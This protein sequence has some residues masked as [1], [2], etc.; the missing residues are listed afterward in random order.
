[1][2][3]HQSASGYLLDLGDGSIV[4][5]QTA[6]PY[7]ALKFGAKLRASRLGVIDVKEAAL[8][9]GEV[10]NRRVRWDEKANVVTERPRAAADHEAVRKHAKPLDA[11][12]KLYRNQIKNPLNP[13]E[14]VVLLD[15]SRFGSVGDALVAEDAAGGRLV[16]RDP[17]RAA[18]KTTL[19]LKN[20]A[21]AFGPEQI[22]LGVQGRKG[23]AGHARQATSTGQRPPYT[24][25]PRM[26]S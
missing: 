3:E 9:P 25:K 26:R 10:V 4:E 17:K 12:V 6:L 2:T 18:F 11:L 16:I 15:V 22:E 7:K 1:M 8:Y 20:A 5:E 21:G 19:N 14:A 13:A 23:K 24:P